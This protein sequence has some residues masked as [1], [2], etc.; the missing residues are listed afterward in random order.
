MNCPFCNSKRLKVH[1]K[2]SHAYSTMFR[3][4]DCKRFFS[5]RRDGFGISLRDSSQRAPPR[6]THF[7]ELDHTKLGGSLSESKR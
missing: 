1:Q 6:K 2:N 4:A 5:E 7:L 3:C